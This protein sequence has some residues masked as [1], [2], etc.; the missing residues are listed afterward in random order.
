M[1]YETFIKILLDSK[2]KVAGKNYK[3]LC[4]W[5][6][7]KTPSLTISTGNNC[8]HCFGCGKSGTIEELELKFNEKYLTKEYCEPKN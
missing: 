7:E 6:D 2:F 1:N 3:M 8:F 4:L 5:H